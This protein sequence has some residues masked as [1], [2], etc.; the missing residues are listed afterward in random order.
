MLKAL[1]CAGRIERGIAIENKQ[2][3]FQ[4]SQIT[5]AGLAADVRFGD[6]L[7]PLEPGE[8]DSLSICGMGGQRMVRIL[9]AFPERVAPRIVLQPNKQP[10]RVRQWALRSGFRLRDEQIAH[11]HWP[12]PILAFERGDTAEDPAYVGVD[13]QAALLF[14]PLIIKRGSPEFVSRLREE[15]RYLRELDGNSPECGDRLAAIDRL[16]AS[17]ST[18]ATN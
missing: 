3:P 2:Q 15:Q 18:A 1:L 6:G 9:A 8:A 13:R 5:L 12:Y 10:E 4:N 7:D 11:G 17:R 14:G 16:L